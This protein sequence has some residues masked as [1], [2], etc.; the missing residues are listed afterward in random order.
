MSSHVETE[1]DEL[2][3]WANITFKLELL[4]VMKVRKRSI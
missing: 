2:S 4:P 1:Y 3:D